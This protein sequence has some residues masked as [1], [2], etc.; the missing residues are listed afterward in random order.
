MSPYFLLLVLKIYILNVVLGKSQRAS[1]AFSLPRR[2][3]RIDAFPTKHVKTLRNHARFISLLTHVASHHRFIR[4]DFF[5]Q[6]S[7][8]AFSR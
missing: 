5:L 6:R 7:S 4:V 3:S 8:S 1:G 2:D